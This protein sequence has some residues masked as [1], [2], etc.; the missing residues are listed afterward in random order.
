MDVWAF[1][2]NFEEKAADLERPMQVI[3]TGLANYSNNP[4]DPYNPNNT[5]ITNSHNSTL[6]YR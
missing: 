5:N 1:Q 6:P 3:R 2:L 4:N